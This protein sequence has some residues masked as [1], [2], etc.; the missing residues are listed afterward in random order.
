MM[1][2]FPAS[3]LRCGFIEMD[4]RTHGRTQKRS[5]THIVEKNNYF[6]HNKEDRLMKC[7]KIEIRKKDQHVPTGGP[8]K[9]YIY[10][11]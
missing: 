5:D 3:S 2:I 10:S 7:S 6:V 8:D 4:P 1:C 11:I 9:R